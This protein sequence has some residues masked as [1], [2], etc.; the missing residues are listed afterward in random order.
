MDVLWPDAEI[1]SLTVTFDEVR[2]ELLE[3]SGR[4]VHVSAFG[5]I[6]MQIEGFWDDVAVEDAELVEGDPFG[7]RCWESIAS[8]GVAGFDTG[9]V[10][11]NTRS[12]STLVVTFVDGCRMLLA[13]ARF[14]AA[15][16]E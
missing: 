4:C 16:V 11:R 9:S 12:F 1:Q 2:I 10:D 15:P 13:A 7:E 8:R 6:G 3:G 5:H 14:A